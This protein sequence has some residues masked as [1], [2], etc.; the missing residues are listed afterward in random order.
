VW[1][2]K[3]ATTKKV[4]G[5]DGFSTLQILLARQNE[6]GQLQQLAC[7]LNYG[8]SDVQYNAVAK[9]RDIGGWF[10]IEHLARFFDQRHMGDESV[11]NEQIRRRALEA[12][13]FVVAPLPVGA[14]RPV[15]GDEDY[16]NGIASGKW[17]EWIERNR[18]S[19]MKLGPVSER[20]PE[21]RKACT[22]VLQNDLS[23]L[24]ELHSQ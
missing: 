23:A 21:S 12:L 7:E 20:I 13:S 5:D 6:P 11:N 10:S 15:I 3:L 14:D 1:K 16:T 18:D 2:R 8:N 22:Q 19:L 4:F 17:M 9:L 24:G